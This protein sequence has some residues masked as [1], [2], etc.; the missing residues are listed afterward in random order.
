MKILLAEDERA[1]ANLFKSTLE[2]R[3]HDVI[4]AKDGDICLKEYKNSLE[5]L[6][7]ETNKKSPFD[8]VVLDIKMP[9]KDGIQTAKEILEL[10][11]SQR[12]LFSS[13]YVKEFL[14]DEIEYFNEIIGV[15]EKPIELSIL[16][17]IIED[18]DAYEKLE[19]LKIRIQQLDDIDPSKPEIR[20]MIDSATKNQ[21]PDVWYSVGNLIVG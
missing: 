5:K 13:A 11:P 9:N 1:A 4:I 2:K 19:R 10:N 15:L 3:N 8:V 14:V 12:I 16:A 17:D 21:K 7:S 20:D 6:G 18:K